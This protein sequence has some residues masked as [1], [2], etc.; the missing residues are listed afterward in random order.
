MSSFLASTITLVAALWADLDFRD[1]GSVYHRVSQDPYILNE[2]AAKI[3]ARNPDFASYRPTLCVIVTWSQA[4]LFSE[5]FI[6]TVVSQLCVCD[7]PMSLTMEP[8]L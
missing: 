4:V 8:I 7:M 1:S 2:A 6:D 5:S 3:A